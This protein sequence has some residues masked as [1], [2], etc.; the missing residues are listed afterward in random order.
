[1]DKYLPDV[2]ILRFLK[3]KFVEIKETHPLADMIDPRWPAE[4]DI[5]KL[6]AKSSGQFIYASVVIKFLSSPSQHPAQ[7]LEIVQGLQPAGNDTPFAQLD[8]L[9]RHI[10]STVGGPPSCASCTCLFHT[11]GRD[12]H[13]C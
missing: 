2:D 7:R 8:A 9:Y 1:M 10:F 5:H 3:D 6:V 4:Q 11:R 13:Q 12:V